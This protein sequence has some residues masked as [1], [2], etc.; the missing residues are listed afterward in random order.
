MTA[1]EMDSGEASD[2][3][4]PRL[5]HMHPRV[6]ARQGLQLPQQPVASRN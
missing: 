5:R 1:R 6:S 3:S 2:W 4:K